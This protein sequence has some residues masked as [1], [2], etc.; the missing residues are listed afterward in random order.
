MPS[1]ICTTCG[2]AHALSAKPPGYCAI[3]EDNR[4]YVN[5]DGQAWTTLTELQEEHSNDIRDLE[6]GLVGIGATPQIAIGQRALAITRP[7]G[8]VLW[9][10]TP[11]VTDEAVAALT[12]KGGIRAIAISHPHFFASMV[13]WSRALG[14]VPIWLHADHRDFV[15][16]DDDSIRF[17]EGESH[18]LGDGISL[19]RT[20]G[21]FPGSTVLHW[22]DGAAGRGVLMTGDSIMVVPDTRWASFMY[23]YP[24][25][26]PL[27]AARV[28]AIAR[29][30]EPLAFDRIYAGWWDR[31]MVDNAK[32]NLAR[33]VDRYI[34]AIA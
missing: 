12:A 3:C 20:G 27:N 31:V 19:V 15:M 33:S 25:L 30:V 34:A 22:R 1:Y 2:V 11:L 18:N 26:V 21:H 6:P 9:D 10:C 4:Q 32:A 24:N 16:R 8:G 23:S 7:G 5:A 14:G 13:D 17:W 29:A 28:R